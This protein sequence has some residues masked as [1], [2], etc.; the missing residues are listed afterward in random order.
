MLT[1]DYVSRST[2]PH[3][4]YISQFPSWQHSIGNLASTMSSPS[5]T[6]SLSAKRK[7][8]M[9]LPTSVKNSS[10]ADL[11]QPS[12]RD[13][14]G[15][16]AEDDSAVPE[17]TSQKH[18]KSAASIDSGIPPTKRARKHSG[19]DESTTTGALNGTTP[20]AINNEDPGEGSETTEG[21]TDIANRVRRKSFRNGTTSKGALDGGK[22]AMSGDQAG[23]AMSPPQ[24]AGSIAPKGYTMNPP[25]TGRAVRV[26]A[27]G[28][29]D[30]FH[31]G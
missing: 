6:G 26:Y 25:P 7:R 12:S 20:A 1:D 4:P 24:K 2:V 29:F 8:T 10:T 15:E 28:V 19:T 30:L 5:S 22:R 9:N 11:L 14:S 16:D 17:Q 18:K 21:S 23:Q 13:A 3:I 31:L 27:D